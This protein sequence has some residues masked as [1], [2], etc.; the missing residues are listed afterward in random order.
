MDK[1]EIY[2][3][4]YNYVRYY[5]LY[6]VPKELAEDLTQDTFIKAFKA[7][8]DGKFDGKNIKAWLNKMAKNTLIDHIRKNY[9]EVEFRVD[10]EG[11]D[12]DIECEDDAIREEIDYM[13]KRIKDALPLINKTQAQVFMRYYYDGVRAIEIGEEMGLSYNT[14]VGMLR[15]ARIN[16][17]KLI[18]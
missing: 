10:D 16:I 3:N 7:L 18:L 15:Y 17:K 12:Y 8:D 5:A 9:K 2:N 6:G 14:I 1:T 4:N 11:K 13:K